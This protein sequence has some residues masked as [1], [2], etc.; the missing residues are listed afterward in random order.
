MNQSR[1]D[2]LV[3]QIEEK[4][5]ERLR[6]FRV[7]D[8]IKQ[9]RLNLRNPRGGAEPRNRGEC[10]NAASIYIDSLD[11]QLLDEGRDEEGKFEGTAQKEVYERRGERLLSERDEQTILYFGHLVISS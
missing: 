5:H 7:R 9:N 6:E 3:L 8:V 1:A 4:K 2:R 10:E 11:D